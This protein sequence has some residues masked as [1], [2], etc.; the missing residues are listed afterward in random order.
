MILTEKKKQNTSDLFVDESKILLWREAEAMR[1]LAFISVF[2]AS[3]ACIIGIVAVP[4]LYGYLQK[5]QSVLQVN[6]NL[7]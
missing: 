7:L 5:A 1:Q 3:I 2:V 6:F 4:M